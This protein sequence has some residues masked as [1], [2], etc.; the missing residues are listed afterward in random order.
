MTPFV[1]FPAGKTRLTPLPDLVYTDLLVQIR[2]LDELKLLLY[3]LYYLNRQLGYPRYMTMAELEGEGL[4]LSAL[5]H[6]DDD[7]A[8]VLVERLRSAV[9][10]CVHRGTLLRLEIVDDSGATVYLFANTAQGRQAVD[11]VRAGE[12][13]LER[14]GAVREPHIEAPRPR[15]FELYEQNI[16]LLQP[17]L[18]EQL[19][20]AERD[21]PAE[22]IEEAFRIAAVNNARSWRYI[23]AILRRWATEGKG[24]RNTRSARQA[25][26]QSTI[27]RSR[28]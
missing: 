3:M 25:R 17:L 28:R 2:D 6:E 26:H 9:E 23:D 1:G 14:R 27:R 24:Q 8:Q 21:Y 20:E 7:S 19:Q 15:I 22:W 12:L 13:V 5:K 16:G 10:L 18:A 4:L 11:E